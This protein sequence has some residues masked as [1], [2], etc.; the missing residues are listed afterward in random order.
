ME[1]RQL[2]THLLHLSGLLSSNSGLGVCL[3]ALS[4][5]VGLHAEAGRAGDGPGQAGCQGVV[6]TEGS[7]AEHGPLLLQLRLRRQ[8][9]RRGA[10]DGVHTDVAA[11]THLQA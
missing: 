6:E 5:P 8:L 10:V 9:R 1:Q 11:E 7:P 2:Q 3:D 4:L